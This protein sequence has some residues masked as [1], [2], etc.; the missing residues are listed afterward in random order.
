ML[1]STYN[2]HCLFLVLFLTTGKGTMINVSLKYQE[3]S[4]D[5]SGSR[6]KWGQGGSNTVRL[7]EM[8]IDSALNFEK[9]LPELCKNTNK[10]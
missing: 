4:T 2:F 1:G 7:L 5:T 8:T 10:N 9:H 3:I 6:K